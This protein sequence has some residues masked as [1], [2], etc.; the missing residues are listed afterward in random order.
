MARYLAV[1][2]SSHA[3][4]EVATGTSI[5]TV[6]QVATPSTTDL[7]VLAW[8]I[9]FDATSGTPGVVTLI[10]TD[11]AASVTDVTPEKWRNTYAPASLC[12]GSGGNKTGYNS[13]SEGS[14]ADSVIL[15]T[16][17]VNPQTGYS[18]WFPDPPRVQV[19]RYLRI[20]CLFAADVNCIP[21]ILWQEPA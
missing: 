5:K 21:W 9:S 20:R 11:V 12:V 17:E 10:H 6:L 15:D 13:T 8:G 18:I 4:V 1:P 2:K 19:S 3:A 16:Q 14:I 7:A